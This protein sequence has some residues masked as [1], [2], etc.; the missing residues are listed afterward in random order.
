MADVYDS[1]SQAHEWE[2]NVLK[3]DGQQQARVAL[4][5]FED[6]AVHFLVGPSA[7]TTT[8]ALV[9]ALDDIVH[10][11]DELQNKLGIRQGS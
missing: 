9:K 2:Q 4:A 10:N 8:L 5:A 11:K 3:A 1:N 7:P 6:E